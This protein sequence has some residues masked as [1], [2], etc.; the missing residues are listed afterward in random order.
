MKLSIDCPK[1]GYD[2]VEDIDLA[3]WNDLIEI[4]KS[5]LENIESEAKQ[6]IKDKMD[7]FSGYIPLVPISMGKDS[8]VTCHLVNPKGYS[9]LRYDEHVDNMTDD[10]YCDFTERLFLEFDRVLNLGG[11]VLY[12][13]SYGNNNRDGMYKAVNTIITKTPFT[14]ADVICW[15]KKTALP[16]NCSPNKLTRIWE[17]VFVFCRK[18]DIDIFYCNKPVVGER[19]TGQKSYGNIF[20]Y[21]EA[22]NNDGSCPYNKATYSSDLCKQLLNIYCPKDGIVYD[23]FMGTGTTAVACKE[24]GLSYIGSELSENQCKWADDRIKNTKFY[25]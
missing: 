11:V 15:K 22:K 24:L 12:N 5:H 14:I 1:S 13:L 7:K 19:K 23:P 20:N 21:I 25:R 9:Y 8:M 17:S 10:E 4:N 18:T 2:K 16:N 6:L 3:S